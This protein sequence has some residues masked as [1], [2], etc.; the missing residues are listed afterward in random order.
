MYLFKIL[1][2]LPLLVSCKAE[3]E[4]IA[5]SALIRHGA[6]IPNSFYPT[7]PYSNVTWPFVL[8]D[9]TNL[10]ITEMFHV[11]QWL[12]RKYSK[13]LSEKYKPDE[14]Y[15]HSVDFERC[16]MTGEATLAGLYP[17][18]GEEIWNNRIRWQPIPIHGSP[19]SQDIET[20]MLEP[21]PKKYQAVS[22]LIF[23]SPEYPAIIK[24]YGPLL[25]YLSQMAGENITLPSLYPF[26][27]TL[28]SEKKLGLPLP[29]WAEEVYPQILPAIVLY[30]KLNSMTPLEVE[31]Q[32]GP[33]VTQLLNQFQR[34][35]SGED[36]GTT[37]TIYRKFMIYFSTEWMLYD[38]TYGLG[39]EGIGIP[40][41][42]ALYLIELRRNSKKGYYVNILYRRSATPGTKAVPWRFKGDGYSP[43]YE[44]FKKYLEPMK[45]NTTQWVPMCY[46]L[47]GAQPKTGTGVPIS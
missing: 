4:L 34:A 47:T 9:L 20:N 43:S 3:D 25:D 13:F 14:L 18:V 22:N 29:K 45:T 24:K 10:G 44:S 26:F 31:V 27:D 17:P 40:E 41:Y 11:G 1:T 33:M 32:T 28:F 7:D 30:T 39:L 37:S 5:V 12:R 36:F 19:N 46:N 16:Y 6:R 23:D 35:I 38:F 8:G 42:G 2:F 15:A 21:C